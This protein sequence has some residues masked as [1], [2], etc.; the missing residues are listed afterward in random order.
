[1]VGVSIFRSSAKSSS[2]TVIA[3]LVLPIG[4][5]A[6]MAATQAPPTADLLEI[7]RPQFDGGAV[8][9]AVGGVIPGIAIAGKRR[10][11]GNALFRDQALE[12]V[13]PVP[14]VG[15]A[16]IGIARRLRPLDLGSERRRP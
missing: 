4:I 8:R 5:A 3:C 15:S 2:F 10:P 14:I 16:K 1:M 12:G 6:Y 7:F 11:I 13:E 9:R